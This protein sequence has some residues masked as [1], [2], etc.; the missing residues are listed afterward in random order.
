MSGCNPM[1]VPLSMNANLDKDE[2]DVDTILTLYC[3][4]ISKLTYLT[5]N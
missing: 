2:W 1:L 3:Q 5:N 4:I